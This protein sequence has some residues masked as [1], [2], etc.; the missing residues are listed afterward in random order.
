MTAHQILGTD[1]SNIGGLLLY[2]QRQLPQGMV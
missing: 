2:V 1:W